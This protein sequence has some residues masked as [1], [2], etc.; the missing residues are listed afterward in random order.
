MLSHLADVLETLVDFNISEDASE[1]AKAT[2]QDA[3]VLNYFKEVE[4]LPEEEKNTILKVIGA[5]VAQNKASIFNLK[6]I[7]MSTITLKELTKK[8]QYASP[9]ILERILGYADALL[10][11]SKEQEFV[12][13]EE[14]RQQ[15][16]KQ[17]PLE[18]YKDAEEVY[19]QLKKKY[20]L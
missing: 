6:Y 12:L 9:S 4:A 16:L 15:L 8:L 7:F 2:L 17:V 3:K 5:I 19:H 10:E 18:D 20:D 1:K 13:S 14:Q 11:N